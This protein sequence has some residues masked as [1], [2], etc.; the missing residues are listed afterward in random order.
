MEWESVYCSVDWS[1]CAFCWLSFS[2]V[3]DANVLLSITSRYKLDCTA[4]ITLYTVRNYFSVYFVK[5]LWH[6]VCVYGGGGGEIK[7]LQLCESCVWCF[8]LIYCATRNCMKL[9]CRLVSKYKSV[10]EGR[11]W[12]NNETDSLWYGLPLSNLI[13]I[14]SLFSEIKHAGKQI[15]LGRH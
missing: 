2:F 11:I 9:N 7:I 10:Y 5:Y 14:Y 12:V 8:E 15:V 1:F 3:V 13:E 6:C 4:D